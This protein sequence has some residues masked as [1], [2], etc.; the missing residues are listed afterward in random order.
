MCVLLIFFVLYCAGLKSNPD[1][2]VVPRTILIGGK[3]RSCSLFSFPTHFITSHV[4]AA[5]GY[6][7]AKMIIKLINSVADGQ[8]S[9]YTHYTVP[10]IQH[11][12]PTCVLVVCSGE[13]WPR[14]WWCAEGR[15]PEKLQ[16]LTSWKR[17]GNNHLSVRSSQTH[18]MNCV[19]HSSLCIAVIPATDLSEQ[20]SIHLFLV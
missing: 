17:Y 16:S 10:P 11:Y 3:V 7:A 18:G 14:H 9:S 19:L 13:Q 15:V 6:H 20:V 5:P 12:L 1:M 8:S 2:A 4:Q